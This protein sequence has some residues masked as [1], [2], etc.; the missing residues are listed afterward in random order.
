MPL[1]A[2]FGKHMIGFDRQRQTRLFCVRAKAVR[3]PGIGL[4][5]L[6]SSLS[7]SGGFIVSSLRTV[8]SPALARP[9]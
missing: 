5:E 2:E 6:D 9:A 7:G 1:G 4:P 3:T 8:L